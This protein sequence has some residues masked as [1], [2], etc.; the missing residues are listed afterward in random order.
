VVVVVGV[1]SLLLEDVANAAVA[2]T[3]ITAGTI[4]GAN[5]EP[6]AAVVAAVAPAA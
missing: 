4:A 6:A 5:A 1:V 3:E 2:L